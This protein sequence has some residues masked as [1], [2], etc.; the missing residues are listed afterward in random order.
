MLGR[1][2]RPSYDK[3]TPLISVRLFSPVGL[4][5]VPNGDSIPRDFAGDS[6]RDTSTTDHN[7][8]YG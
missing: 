3:S 6:V 2:H 7:R 5:T 1:K 4:W 8:C